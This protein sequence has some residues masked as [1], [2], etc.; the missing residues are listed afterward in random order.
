MFF[1]SIWVNV[2]YLNFIRNWSPNWD[3]LFLLNNSQMHCFYGHGT[4]NTPSRYILKRGEKPMVEMGDG[5]GLVNI[6]SLRICA[7]WKQMG[8]PVIFAIL[9]FI[10]ISR[11]PCMNTPTRVM[12]VLRRKIC[13]MKLCK[14]CLKNDLSIESL[15]KKF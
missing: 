10:F 7:I 2:Q 13:W 1:G 4:R 12:S 3:D 6:E 9:K 5:D 11:L 15:N 8:F 14:F